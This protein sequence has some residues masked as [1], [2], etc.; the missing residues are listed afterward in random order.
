MTSDLSR[1][2]PLPA[3][4]EWSASGRLSFKVAVPPSHVVKAYFLAS[5]LG[6]ALCLA[7]QSFADPSTF[8]PILTAHSWNGEDC[9]ATCV[10]GLQRQRWLA[11][12]PGK[13]GWSLEPTKL[14]FDDVNAKGVQ[15][16]VDGAEFYLAHPAVVAGHAATPNMRFKGKPYQF[17]DKHVAPLRIAFHDRAYEIGVEGHDVV[18]RSGG[19]KSVI[20]GIDPDDSTDTMLFWAGDLD[21]DGEIDLIVDRSNS[22]NGQYCLMLS[23]ANKNPD[24]IVADVGCQFFSG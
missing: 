1:S 10:A 16:S 23:S 19:R 4:R 8:G 20:G 17:F 6:L 22:K 3:V 11:L 21:G 14:S 15:S 2:R 7:D 9:D 24:E 12:V 5:A 13:D 18:L